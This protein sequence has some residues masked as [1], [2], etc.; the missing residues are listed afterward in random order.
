METEPPSNPQDLTA[1]VTDLLE[2]MRAARV[3]ELVRSRHDASVSPP[4]PRRL[5]GRATTRHHAVAAPQTKTDPRTHRR[6]TRFESMSNQIVA[7]ID[8]MGQR[9]DDLE[10]SIGELTDAAGIAPDVGEE[11]A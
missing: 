3:R 7:R 4:S 5:S 11:K 8:E 10:K 6:Q 2:Q 9:I 1:F